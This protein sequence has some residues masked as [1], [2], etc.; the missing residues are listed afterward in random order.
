MNRRDFLKAA[1]AVSTGGIV[2]G[3]SGCS[4][5]DEAVPG[6]TPI[7]TGTIPPTSTITLSP[8]P[9]TVVINGTITFTASGG[10]SPYTFVLLNGSGTIDSIT[11]TYTAPS[12]TGSATVRVY[13]STG[14]FADSAITV[15][16]IPSALPNTIPDLLLWLKADAGV[17]QVAGSVTQWADQSGNGYHMVPGTSPNYVT[18]VVNGNPVIRFGGS[19]FLTNSAVPTPTNP[20]IIVV[21]SAQTSGN[22]RIVSHGSSTQSDGWALWWDFA[23]QFR[24]AFPVKTTPGDP[25]TWYK[26]YVPIAT[27]ISSAGV[28]SINTGIHYGPVNQ[29]S[30]DGGYIQQDTGPDPTI[31]Y[32]TAPVFFNVGAHGDVS[33]AGTLVGDVAEV[34]YYNRAI[35]DIERKGIEVYLSQKYAITLV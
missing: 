3:T 19:Q 14:L 2:A 28:F 6:G 17:T 32:G 12:A 23:N 11:G 9:A 24:V 34:I 29:V 31:D 35:T 16:A 25:T 26:Y 20:T 15:T 8:N 27:K 4:W 1:S 22:T 18:G 33:P 10:G 21:S 30:H 7:W 5:F 13:D